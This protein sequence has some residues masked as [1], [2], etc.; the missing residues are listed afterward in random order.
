MRTFFFVTAMLFSGAA[1]ANAPT[2]AAAQPA[3]QDIRVLGKLNVNE[4]TREQ[5]L[6]VPGLDPAHVDAIVAQRKAGAI[7]D[8]A[9]LGLA[10]AAL[11]HL[12]IDGASDYRRIRPL[13]LQVVNR[14][15]AKR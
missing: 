5:L 6:A 15:S 11:A 10:P 9:P 3:A 13:P 1:N 14:E 2:L 4:A 12:K 8:L 7:V